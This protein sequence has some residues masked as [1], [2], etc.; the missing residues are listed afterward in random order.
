M[1]KSQN[2]GCYRGGCDDARNYLIIIH[3]TRPSDSDI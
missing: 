3:G 2:F 1:N